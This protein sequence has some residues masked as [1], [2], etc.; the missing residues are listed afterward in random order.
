M[1]IPPRKISSLTTKKK[2]SEIVSLV[3]NNSPLTRGFLYPILY[4]NAFLF[5]L[6]INSFAQKKLITGDIYFKFKTTSNFDNSTLTDIL[7]LPREKYFNRLNLEDDLKR[8][9]KFYF[10]HGFF[11]AVV[12]TST[13][14]N[15]DE[16]NIKFIITENSRYTIKQF[17][18]IG[19]DKISDQLKEEITGNSLI[20]EGQPYSRTL[21]TSEKDR[22]L[23]IL[24]N[25][26]YY[27]AK[28]DTARSPVDSSR[29]GIVIGK[30]SGALSTDPEFQN[31][32][33]VRMRITGADEV[34]RIGEIT[35]KI[36]NN[37]YGLSEEVIRREL[38]FNEGDIY[39]K[40]KLLESEKNF[41]KLPIIHLARIFTE[42][43]QG[44]VNIKVVV[45]LNKKYEL[46]PGISAVYLNNRFFAGAT[47]QYSD[48]NFFGGGRVFSVT[49]EG[50]YNTPGNNQI[51]L[52]LSLFQPFLFRSNL[53]ANFTS[54][55]G[56]Y[57]FLDIF[58]YIYTQ[59]LARFNYFIREYT[60]YN[61][62]YLDITYDH[63]RV[64]FKENIIDENSQIIEG[65]RISF[66]NS[67]IG[68]SLV[69]NSTNDLFNPSR[70][71]YHQLTLENAGALPRFISLFNKS[72]LYSQYVKFFTPNRFYFD[73]T[74]GRKTTI[75]A[76]NFEG[77]N[78][79]EYGSG[80]NIVPVDRIYKFYSGGGNSLRGWSAQT[81][82]ILPDTKDGGK[83]LVEGSFEIRRRPFPPRS[84]MFPV[85]AVV[86]L[87][88]GN[89]W[90]SAGYF[91]LNQI[92]LSTGIGIRYETFVGPIRVDLGFKLYNPS[93]TEDNRWLW[94]Q[95]SKIF[96]S[97]YA[98]QFGIGN[99][100]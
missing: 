79:T 50:L 4:L 63:L 84:F 95:P 61:N 33:L 19:T 44:I 17:Q 53:T 29:Q 7:S 87:D 82:G 89:V 90:E 37:R 96:R 5:F 97:K 98:I 11:D 77:G 12:D 62:A 35:V 64:R 22:I 43:E 41:T 13:K 1:T 76:F 24:W 72:L 66:S 60:F 73:L 88:W 34:Y 10:D 55:I 71:F 100:F 85:W 47:L 74:G 23:N 21:V 32:V 81:N 52:S 30:Y 93:E 46:T 9:E 36:E 25:N 40:S 57:N 18:L 70:G 65:L 16:I 38:K 39:N 99:A 69:H 67:V 54:S 48:K 94:Q 27:D 56:L 26:G 92:A 75:F 8:L 51:E 45:T 20:K 86:F 59:N 42:K 58:E 15:D 14:V 83:F 6:C 3:C 31:K 2:I 68:F 49:L 91:R 78:I 80:N 28:I